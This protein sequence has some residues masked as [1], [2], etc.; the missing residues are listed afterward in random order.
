MGNRVFV[1]N[2][3]SLGEH[4]DALFEI[5]KEFDRIAKILGTPYLLFAGTMLGAVRHGGFIP[6]DDDLDVIMLRRDYEKFLS[7]ASKHLDQER[8][9]F[10]K[11]FSEHWP[12]FFSK[13]RM[14]DTACL[15]KFHPKDKK[16]HQGVYIDVFPCDNAIKSGFGRRAQHLA[17]KVVIAKCLDKRGY[18]TRDKGKVLFMALCRLFPL[19]P[20]LRFAKFGGENSTMVHSFFGASSSYSK[21]V[22]PRNCFDRLVVMPFEGGEFPVSERYDEL[23]RILYGDYMRIP[24]EDERKCKKHAILVDLCNS[25]ESYE[26]YRD[27]MKFEVETR[28]IR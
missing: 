26:G 16:I 9:F 10:Q 28:S 7:E 8:F 17:S 11:E 3:A 6:W 18:E 12:M 23:L 27:G 15:E 13:L 14:N 1:S 2:P 24:S 19:K 20:F 5:L 22:Y 25:Y 4:Q 21:S